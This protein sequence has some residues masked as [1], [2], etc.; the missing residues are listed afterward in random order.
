[1]SPK[2]EELEKLYEKNRREFLRHSTKITE[3]VPLLDIDEKRDSAI[4]E[5]KREIN[6]IKLYMGELY[7]HCSD[8]VRKTI[9]GLS[10]KGTIICGLADSELFIRNRSAILRWASLVN[11]LRLDVRRSRLDFISGLTINVSLIH[12]DTGPSMLKVGS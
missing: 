4:T 11:D 9:D 7:P 12:I 8:R 1:M 2:R 6:T 3:R 10:E 5:I